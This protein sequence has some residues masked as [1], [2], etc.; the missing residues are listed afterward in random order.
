M[1]CQLFLYHSFVEGSF[2]VVSYS[3][4]SSWKGKNGKGV[5]ELSNEC[6][7]LLK[8]KIYTIVLIRE[9]EDLLKEGVGRE[10]YMN[11]GC[12]QCL[13]KVAG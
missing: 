2:T 12:Q 8:N 4:F 7:A 6:L 10:I 3:S 5:L 13:G 11:S 9:T 1:R